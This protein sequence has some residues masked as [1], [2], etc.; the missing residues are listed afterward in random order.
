[1]KKLLVGMGL[2]VI[3]GA[4]LGATAMASQWVVAWL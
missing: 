1:M 4:I 3:L 2:V